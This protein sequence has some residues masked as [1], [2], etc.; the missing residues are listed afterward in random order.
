MYPPPP[1]PPAPL[2]LGA[3]WVHAALGQP[4]PFAGAAQTV[5]D[6]PLPFAGDAQTVLDRPLPFADDWVLTAWHHPFGC[7][8]FRQYWPHW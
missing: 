6:W 7:D 5:F 1:P 3:D 4:L 8:P 2:S